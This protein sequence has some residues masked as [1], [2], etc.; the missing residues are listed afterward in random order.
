M[1]PKAALNGDPSR[2]SH[3]LALKQEV[4][5]E[6]NSEGTDRVDLGP[7]ALGA[8]CCWNGLL[9]IPVLRIQTGFPKT[10][11]FMDSMQEQVMQI[12]GF[13]C[14][15]N[16]IGLRTILTVEERAA[17][18]EARSEIM[19]ELSQLPVWVEQRVELLTPEVRQVLC[20]YLNSIIET[21]YE[22][23]EVLSDPVLAQLTNKCAETCLR[24]QFQRCPNS[25]VIASATPRSSR[26]SRSSSPWHGSR[27]QAHGF[28]PAYDPNLALTDPLRG[29]PPETVPPSTHLTGTPLGVYATAATT[30]AHPDDDDSDE[31]AMDD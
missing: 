10:C 15:G 2:A 31:W 6:Q 30:I 14:M 25:A 9:R 5:K 24:C 13:C 11:S 29:S 3:P 19:A 20:R 22:L 1:A 7:F 4:R 12:I 27:S 16:R 18:A 28:G 17:A 21:V 8:F 23:Q 26:S